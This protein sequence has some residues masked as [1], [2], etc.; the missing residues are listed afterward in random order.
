VGPLTL[1]GS[2][3]EGGGSAVAG[4]PDPLVP[5][6]HAGVGRHGVCGGHQPPTGLEHSFESLIVS[7]D[8]PRLRRLSGLA[9]AS[10]GSLVANLGCVFPALILRPSVLSGSR[11]NSARPWLSPLYTHRRRK[12][13]NGFTETV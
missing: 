10:S 3:K 4:P 7:V 6:R 2:K 8:A 1:R 12:N 11:P 13:S 5:V 9:T